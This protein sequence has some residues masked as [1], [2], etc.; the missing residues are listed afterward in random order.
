MFKIFKNRILLE[1]NL[2]KIR[3]SI[4]LP[5]CNMRSQN[6][7]EPD[8]CSRFDVYWTQTNR[9]TLRQV[10]QI[11]VKHSDRFWISIKMRGIPLPPC[12]QLQIPQISLIHGFNGIRFCQIM[13]KVVINLYINLAWVSVFVCLSVCIQ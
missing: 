12:R 8:R 5:W 13:L 9:Q 11:F 1:A 6:K 10:Y 2:L 4:N 7:F 3:S